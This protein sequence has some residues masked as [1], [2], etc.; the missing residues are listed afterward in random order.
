M[1]ETNF[2]T[3][4]DLRP[5]ETWPRRMNSRPMVGDLVRS[6]TQRGRFNSQLELEIVRVTITGENSFDV[7]MHLI[8]GRFNNIGEFHKWYNNF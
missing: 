8:K 3:N 5:G 4:L 2:F 1:I 6:A 7:E